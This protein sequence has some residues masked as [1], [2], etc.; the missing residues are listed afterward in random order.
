VKYQVSFRA[1]TWYLH[2]WKI[3]CYFHMWK[4]HSCYGYI[5]NQAFRSEKIFRWN[6]LAFHWCLYNKLNITWLLGDTK[7]LFEWWISR[8]DKFR[9]SAQPCNI[10]YIFH[11]TIFL[12]N[13]LSDSRYFCSSQYLIP[14]VRKNSTLGLATKVWDIALP[15]NVCWACLTCCTMERN[16]TLHKGRSKQ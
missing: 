15:A 8:E 12:S 5:I 2:T 16:T 6:G 4:E 9:I 10:L 11:D 7:F 13:K 3:T 1:K 14:K